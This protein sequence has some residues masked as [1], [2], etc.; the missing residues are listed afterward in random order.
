MSDKTALVVLGMHRS[1]TSSVAGALALLG[2]QPPLTLLQP[3]DDNP[4]G[5][6]E[7][8]EII[9]LNDRILQA[10]ESWWND[11]RPFDERKIS[12]AQ[13][14]AFE[15]DIIRTVGSEFGDASTIVLKD[16]RCCRLWSF[17]EPALIR[18]GYKPLYILPIRAPLEV[19][20]SLMAR[21]G[22]SLAEGLVLWLRHVLEAERSTRGRPRLISL[23]ARFMADWRSELRRAEQALTWTAPDLEGVEGDAVDE[24]LQPDLRRQRSN[25]EGGREGHVWADEAFRLMTKLATNDHPDVQAELDS[26]SSV[27]ETSCDLYGRALG[28][29]LWNAHVSLTR[30]AERDEAQGLAARLRD[31]LSQS[32]QSLCETAELARQQAGD[33]SEIRSRMELM[34]AEAR[35]LAV[36][37]DLLQAQIAAL[38]DRLGAAV[39]A[40]D[41]AMKACE[42]LKNEI[43][44][45]NILVG[46]LR[47]N[48]SEAVARE[49]S[50]Q[51]ELRSQGERLETAKAKLVDLNE[52]LVRQPLKTLFEIKIKPALARDRRNPDP[53][54]GAIDPGHP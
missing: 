54:D 19:A 37:Q 21:N 22:F 20:R 35:S 36:A 2:A 47:Q 48:L 12:D 41:S 9:H 53:S 43:E 32:K 26:F 8:L 23:W 46:T 50:A 51:D 28:P 24:F 45:Q 49:A 39:P 7:S 6:W 18:A 34:T 52:N 17:W 10:G 25:D 3:S 44:E 38:E 31:E 14:E 30:Q 27:F 13:R 16:P 4:R 33:L 5:F 42:D 29:I 11:W 40:R 1:G 15:D